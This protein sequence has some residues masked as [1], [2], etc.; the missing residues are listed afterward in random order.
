MIT[1][2]SWCYKGSH[3]F[4]AQ[5]TLKH[6]YSSGLCK[7][8]ARYESAKFELYMRKLDSGVS[9]REA[10]DLEQMKKVVV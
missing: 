4:L 10:E 7:F 2:C 3:K 5:K 9:N 8:H 6:A 1:K